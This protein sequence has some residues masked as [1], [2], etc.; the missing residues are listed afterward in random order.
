MIPDPEQPAPHTV[1]TTHALFAAAYERLKAM[2]VNHLARARPGETLQATA[3]V[4]DLYLRMGHDPALHFS[5]RAQF[6]AYAARAMRHLLADRAR[7]RMRQRA[8]GEWVRV[9]LTGDQEQFAIESAEAA[10]QLEDA[11]AQLALNDARAAQVL[12]L[13]YFA[14]L[15]VAEVADVLDSSPRTVDRDWLFARAFLKVALS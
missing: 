4:H 10:L 1:E 9:T 3:L 7:D 15:T 5:H 8:G 13:R 11:I 6:F 12:E 2:A 14:G